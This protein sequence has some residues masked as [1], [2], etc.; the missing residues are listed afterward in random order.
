MLLETLSMS[1]FS[2]GLE[3]TR[4]IIVP[5]GSLEEHGPHLPLSTDTVHAYELAKAASLHRPLFVAPPLNYGLCRSTG[6]HPGTV[7][8]GGE[9]LRRLTI[10][11]ITSLYRQGLRNFLLMSG[12]AGGTHMAYLTDAG[13]E[14]LH[15]CPESKIAVFSVLDFLVNLP[16]GLLETSGDSHAGELETSVMLHLYPHW[17]NGSASEDY[18]EFPRPLLVR[19]KRKFW[20]SGIWGD[21]SKAS[22]IKGRQFFEAFVGELLNLVE[23]I[24]SFKE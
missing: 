16:P 6:E 20:N 12:H 23:K 14:L 17:V 8:I 19:N 9:T 22:G 3:R 4:T 15:S 7:S 5:Y 18:P 1:Q 11:I 2:Q 24:E 10:D 13:E 21:P